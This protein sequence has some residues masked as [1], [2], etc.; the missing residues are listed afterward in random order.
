[1][2]YTL[3]PWTGSLLEENKNGERIH[4][5][6]PIKLIEA[7]LVCNNPYLLPPQATDTYSNKNER[8]QK[9][10]AKWIISLCGIN[11]LLA[12]WYASFSTPFFSNCSEANA[13][14]HEA[15]STNERNKLCLPRS[16]FAAKTSK[17]FKNSGVIL[18]GVFLP[19]RQMHAWIIEDGQQVDP[20][21]KIWHLYQPVAAIC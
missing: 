2:H 14:F 6:H 10:K 18:I 5:E 19:S 12:R 16:L 20:T 9:L 8:L 4:E 15:T 3:C 13:F 7:L 21:D 11:L 17:I 1:M